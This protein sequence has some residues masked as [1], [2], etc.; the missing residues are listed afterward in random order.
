[1]MNNTDDRLRAMFNAAFSHTSDHQPQ[2]EVERLTD[3]QIDALVARPIARI[4]LCRAVESAC[5]A[6]WGVKLEE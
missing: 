4:A 5:S 1:M 3:E 2:R 6:A